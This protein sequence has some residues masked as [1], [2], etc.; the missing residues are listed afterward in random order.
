MN[1]FI[2]RQPLGQHGDVTLRLSQEQYQTL[3]A[4]KKAR[5]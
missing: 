3:H 1:C 2:F 5:G 4:A